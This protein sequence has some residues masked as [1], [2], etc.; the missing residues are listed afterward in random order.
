MKTKQAT[1]LKLITRASRTRDL[2]QINLRFISTLQSLGWMKPLSASGIELES[3][4]FPFFSPCS[5]LMS[6]RK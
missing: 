6:N 5:A 1:E 3:G 4:G 2:L